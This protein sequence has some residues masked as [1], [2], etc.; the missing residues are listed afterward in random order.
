MHAGQEA[1]LVLGVCRALGIEGRWA[2]G[3]SGLIVIDRNLAGI[4]FM[5]QPWKITSV[6]EGF[7]S[8]PLTHTH[9][10]GGGVSVRLECHVA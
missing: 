1:M 4:A 2:V 9:W 8:Y 7:M 5:S 3:E 10:E 6:R